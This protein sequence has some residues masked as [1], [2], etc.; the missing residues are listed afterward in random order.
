MA[1]LPEE[2]AGHHHALDLVR[3][4]VDLGD[5]R[6][7]HHALE[8]SCGCSHSHSL[9][10]PSREPVDTLYARAPQR[11]CR[12]PTTPV[13]LLRQPRPRAP[14][15]LGSSGT[16]RHTPAPDNPNQLRPD[17][18]TPHVLAP[19]SPVPAAPPGTHR[20]NLVQ[21]DTARQVP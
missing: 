20:H 8:G 10:K 14:K 3:P 6:I 13:P 4:L 11:L 21:A 7:A 19:C 12:P 1:R 16:R 15:V 9:Y 17:H 5:L 18:A 2:L